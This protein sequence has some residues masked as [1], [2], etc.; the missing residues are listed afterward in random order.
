MMGFKRVLGLKNGFWKDEYTYV[1]KLP[2]RL[3][4]HTKYGF[5]VDDWLQSTER[6][7]RYHAKNFTLIFETE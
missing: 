3:K 1:Y 5:G 6:E 4:P 2:S 7:L